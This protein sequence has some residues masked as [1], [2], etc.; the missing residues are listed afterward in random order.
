MHIATVAFY[1]I[2]AIALGSN[3]PQS[4]HQGILRMRSWV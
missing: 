2:E 4:D 1:A 3:E